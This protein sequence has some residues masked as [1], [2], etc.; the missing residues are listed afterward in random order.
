MLLY[1]IFKINLVLLFWQRRDQGQVSKQVQLYKNQSNN[2][3]S[4]SNKSIRRD[5]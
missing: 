2:K 4:S 1:M 5:L 3:Y